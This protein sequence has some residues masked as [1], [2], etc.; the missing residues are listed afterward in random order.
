MTIATQVDFWEGE[1][2]GRPA[3]VGSLGGP[4]TGAQQ[5]GRGLGWESHQKSSS[6]EPLKGRE[7]LWAWGHVTYCSMGLVLGKAR[8]Q[9][10][11]R[12]QLATPGEEA[13]PPPE[14]YCG[15]WKEV[16]T[17]FIL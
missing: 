10:R 1:A 2:H 9:G 11:C 6:S 13:G 8:G 12:G 4:H 5:W 15:T 16:T 17:R 7:R 14:D 3:R